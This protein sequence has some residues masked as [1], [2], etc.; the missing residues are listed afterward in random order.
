MKIK[1]HFHINSFVFSLALKQRFEATLNVLLPI[2]SENCARFFF[3]RIIIASY[4]FSQ[5]PKK[6][7]STQV[8]SNL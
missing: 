1:N 8:R 7:M 5:E 6:T 4:L 2:R 3:F